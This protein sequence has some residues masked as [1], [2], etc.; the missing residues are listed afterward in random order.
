MF[1][2]MV[3]DHEPQSRNELASFLQSDE[4][5][6]FSC[7]AAADR[8]AA[9]EL[10][11]ASAPDIALI[12]LSLPD[13]GG[14]ELIREWRAS[15]LPTVCILLTATDEWRPEDDPFAQGA[16]DCLSL[17]LCSR[18]VKQSVMEAAQL[19]LNRSRRHGSLQQLQRHWRE[20]LR[21]AKAETLRRWVTTDRSPLENRRDSLEALQ[22][23]LTFSRAHVGVVRL[24]YGSIHGGPH[25]EQ[26]LELLRYGVMNIVQETLSPVYSGLLEAFRDGEHIVWIGNYRGWVAGRL[27]LHLPLLQINLRKYLRLT[28]SIGIGMPQEN[29]N[30]AALSYRQARE[31]AEARFYAGRGGCYFYEEERS[32]AGSAALD[33]AHAERELYGLEM[34]IVDAVRTGSQAKAL[35]GIA[36]WLEHCRS[37]AQY[38]RSELILRAAALIGELRR[39][40]FQSAGSPW[41]GE[42][43]L[44][45][46]VAK[47]AQWETFDELAASLSE[48]VG[49][50][51]G[52]LQRS[53][54]LHRVIQEVLELISGKYDTALTLESAAKSVY[55]SPVYLS[56]LFKKEMG[57]NFLTY[58]HHYRI[59]QAKKLL[60]EQRMKIVSV[61][62]TVGYQNE[63]HFSIT[64]KKWT[65]L[66]PSEYQKQHRR[67]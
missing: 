39:Q 2:V 42:A 11:H 29:I 62:K 12:R 52:H 17:P 60:E 1:T 48:M 6:E 5:R 25:K 35:N 27:K 34:G 36:L 15:G 26:D 3:V 44:E 33:A 8:E 14:M 65:G 50:L 30:S 59:A 13:A 19:L 61:A 67:A 32:A 31:A 24:D 43:Q 4:F 9:R 10:A 16:F 23:A 40:L 53:K 56:R 38:S 45:E 47:L 46:A 57:V 66:T 18:A 63:C 22:L 21:S 54:P 7:V 49:A 51:A 37:K 58:L 41:P 20:H 28:A 55:V 64:F